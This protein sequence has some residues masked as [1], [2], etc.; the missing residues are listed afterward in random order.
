MF[1]T[2]IDDDFS[3]LPDGPLEGVLPYWE[4]QENVAS[5]APVIRSG[6]LV[7]DPAT[8]SS[9]LNTSAI[10]DDIRPAPYTLSNT[11]LR[12]TVGFRRN[13][14]VAIPAATP[15][16]T[17]PGFGSLNTGSGEAHTILGGIDYGS[18]GDTLGGGATPPTNKVDIS[19]Y[20]SDGSGGVVQSSWEGVDAPAA[21]WNGTRQEYVMSKPGGLGARWTVSVNG[22]S[23]P[24][25]VALV[26][27]E[28]T[29]NQ[30]FF[31]YL[32]GLPLG[33]SKT[34]VLD[35]K[36]EVDVP[37]PASGSFTLIGTPVSIDT[38]PGT[39]KTRSINY[40]GGRM[41]SIINDDTLGATFQLMNN[42]TGALTGLDVG[43]DFDILSLGG[44]TISGALV[45]I[46]GFGPGIL[47]DLNSAP[48]LVLIQNGSSGSYD[49]GSWTD[50]TDSKYV[51][52][53][54]VVGNG[55]NGKICSLIYGT[56]RV[57]IQADTFQVY[58]STP[59]TDGSGVADIAASWA[60]N[61]TASTPRT[62]QGLANLQGNALVCNAT[63]NGGLTLM[64]ATGSYIIGQYTVAG[65]SAPFTSI[66]YVADNGTGLI[67]QAMT[68]GS[69]VTNNRLVTLQ[70][71]FP[72]IV[73]SAIA[74][75]SDV[76]V[77]WEDVTDADS[78]K[79]AKDGGL[80]VTRTNP[81]TDTG[82]ASD[83]HS[84]SVRAYDVTGGIMAQGSI[85]YTPV[86]PT[87]E[88]GNGAALRNAEFLLLLS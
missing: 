66:T 78:Y 7:N 87:P 6:A 24:N 11:G 54:T 13:N 26:N 51:S 77:S 65:V 22:V 23:L 12:L 74:S 20:S 18:T 71:T 86:A 35:I 48:G 10:Y 73:G 44:V 36:L 4:E 75:G 16:Y 30:Y 38:N 56:A 31:Y 62:F 81:Y 39:F 55:T 85:D 88:S 5:T 82:A 58:A 40:Q 49:G 64:S 52:G 33:S 59:A 37:S 1:R 19:T 14:A 84:Y 2:I 60:P 34:G 8:E 69:L 45:Q 28:I 32:S 79:V 15:D 53:I 43:G 25:V 50:T 46:L 67:F 68:Q 42:T 21:S 3:V 63:Q 27:S 80:Y 29:L 17:Q 41:F 83:S 9:A 70:Y 61:G 47:T 76:L 72:V 57:G